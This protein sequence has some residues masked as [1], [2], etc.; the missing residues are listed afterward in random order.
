MMH[1]LDRSGQRFG[2]W[3]VLAQYKRI[4]NGK[5]IVIC[6]LCRCDCSNVRWVYAGS[7]ASGTSRGCR[8]CSEIEN[9]KRLA[10]SYGF[11]EGQPRL[12]QTRWYRVL[13]GAELR[14]LEV[15]ITKDEALALLI[16]QESK[17]AITGW[18]IVTPIRAKGRGTASLDRIDNTRGYIH[19]NVRWTHWRINKMK[20]ALSDKEFLEA[21][22]AVAK[23]NG[24]FLKEAAHA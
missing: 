18:P 24:S 22:I 6:W 4:K 15:T 17:C 21:C 5:H 3:T 11:V 13:Q 1:V 19:G 12:T 9:G 10:S 14:G 2:K 23:T 7:L 8:R 16:R 20:G